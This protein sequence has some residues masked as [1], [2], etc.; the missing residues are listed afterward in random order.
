MCDAHMYYGR[1]EGQTDRWTYEKNYREFDIFF[2]LRMHM[3][4]DFTIS[5]HSFFGLIFLLHDVYYSIYL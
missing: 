1:T 2:M 4:L 3:L 5:F